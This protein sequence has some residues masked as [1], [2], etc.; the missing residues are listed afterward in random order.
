MHSGVHRTVEVMPRSPYIVR[1]LASLNFASHLVCTSF[2]QYSQTTL[3]STRCMIKKTTLL[4][5]LIWYLTSPPHNL[6]THEKHDSPRSDRTQA[7]KNPP[8]DQ[9]HV[10]IPVP[11]GKYA[12]NA[13]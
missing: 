8:R 9:N 10:I 7:S 11:I 3:G 2:G 13:M 1:N 5:P 4:D 6:Y 12:L